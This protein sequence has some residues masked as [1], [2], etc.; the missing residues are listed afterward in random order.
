MKMMYMNKQSHHMNIIYIYT[1]EV[2]K[3]KHKW[4]PRHA[5][6]ATSPMTST[7]TYAGSRSPN[8]RLSSIARFRALGFRVFR[9]LVIFDSR[10]FWDFRVNA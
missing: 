2:G 6:G 4:E 10:V 5:G 8:L 3:Y 9:V 7:H 1:R